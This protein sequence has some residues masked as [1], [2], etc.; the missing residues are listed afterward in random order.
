M[1]EKP[2]RLL[3]IF[4]KPP[5]PGRVKTR[6]AKDLGEQAAT[7][8]YRKLLNLT[9]NVVNRVNCRKQVWLTA[10]AEGGAGI[11]EFQDC[12]TMLQKGANLGER[13]SYAFEQVFKDGN[14]RVVIIGSDCPDI[15]VELIEEA[16]Q[17]LDGSDLVIGPGEDGGYWLLG[18]KEFR[19]DLF[20][21]IAWSTPAVLSQTEEIAGRLGLKISRLKMLN[22]IDTISDLEK[23]GFQK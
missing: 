2:K 10:P 16:F 6:L 23:S 11:P 22:D 8:V 5:V 15:T 13:M 4:A 1:T 20:R 21:E 9:A 17:A 14:D 3:M 7:D 18:M 19:P 12:D